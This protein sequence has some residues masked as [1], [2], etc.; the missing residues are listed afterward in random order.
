MKYK[1]L[2]QLIEHSGMTQA[3]VCAYLG[4]RTERL[5]RILHGKQQITEQ[6]M[7]ELALAL[8]TTITDIRFA[9]QC[10]PD[11]K[12]T[13]RA[14]PW[15]NALI[16]IIT[17]KTDVETMDNTPNF[18]PDCRGALEIVIEEEHRIWWLTR[19]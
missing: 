10:F 19:G 4:W 13:Q 1:R 18:C 15:C 14:C 11:I 17:G 8:G 5:S 16:S 12:H 9:C 7:A 2:K 6:D 3:D